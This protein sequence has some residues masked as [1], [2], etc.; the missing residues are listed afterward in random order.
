MIRMEEL[1]DQNERIESI[2]RAESELHMAMNRLGEVCSGRNPTFGTVGDACIEVTAWISE[3]IRLT[4]ESTDP[5]D[6]AVNEVRAAALCSGNS[7]RLYIAAHDMMR[8]LHLQIQPW[9]CHPMGLFRSQ[10]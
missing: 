10:A 6:H 2:A 7:A 3:V 9:P 1:T 4:S 5:L 8:I